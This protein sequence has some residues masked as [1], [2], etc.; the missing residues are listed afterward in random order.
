MRMPWPARTLP[1]TAAPRATACIRSS[2]GRT[3]AGSK[4]SP[5]IHEF[6]TCIT[7]SRS[8]DAWNTPP[9]SSTCVGQ[10]SPDGPRLTFPYPPAAGPPSPAGSLREAAWRRNRARWR[11]IAASGSYG[12]P[13]SINPPALRRSGISSLEVTGKKPSISSRSTSSRVSLP[14]RLPPIRLE[15]RP[16]IETVSSRLSG[17]E[18]RRSFAARHCCHRPCIWIWSRRRPAA[19]SCAATECASA[20][21]M[22]SPPSSR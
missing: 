21:S 2:P 13:T 12:K 3:C 7:L 11:V 18:S 4:P 9:F 16:R 22:L 14:R 8:S 1:Y 15:P 20:R 19:A 10:V 17:F 5:V 6:R